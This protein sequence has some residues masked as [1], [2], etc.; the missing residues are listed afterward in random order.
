MAQGFHALSRAELDLMMARTQRH[1]EP[2]ASADPAWSIRIG[3]NVV[4]RRQAFADQTPMIGNEVMEALQLHG[5]VAAI[6]L[7]GGAAKHQ[8]SKPGT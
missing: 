6:G 2:I 5:L 4:D 3:G 8:S 1:D 7:Q